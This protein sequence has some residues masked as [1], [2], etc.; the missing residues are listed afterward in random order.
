M[1]LFGEI[2][3]KKII[4]RE[5][6]FFIFIFILL[7][8]KHLLQATLKDFPFT[9]TSGEKVLSGVNICINEPPTASALCGHNNTTQRHD[10]CKME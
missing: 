4:K 10:V 9:E 3:K 2:I 6:T 7:T 5:D 1:Y 8:A